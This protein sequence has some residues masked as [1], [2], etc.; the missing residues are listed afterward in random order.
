MI[1]DYILAMVTMVQLL[2][3]LATNR[4]SIQ[5]LWQINGEFWGSLLQ[6]LGVAT[7]TFDQGVL[8]LEFPSLY[9]VVKM[10]KQATYRKSH[11][12]EKCQSLIFRF[13]VWIG[14][15]EFP[16]VNLAYLNNLRP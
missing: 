12:N 7:A 1:Q 10:F 9:F 16:K 15:V 2:K 6:I 11:F 8:Y 5:T 14:N 3:N 13:L 4:R